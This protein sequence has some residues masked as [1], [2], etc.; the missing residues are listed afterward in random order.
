MSPVL[1]EVKDAEGKVLGR[2][3]EEKSPACPS[4]KGSGQAP[5]W[6]GAAMVVIVCSHCK[7]DGRV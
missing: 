3:Y 7:G 1:K 5:E 6:N 4:C 2:E